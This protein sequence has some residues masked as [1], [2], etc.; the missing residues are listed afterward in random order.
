M[1]NLSSL[2]SSSHPLFRS[3][4]Q[5]HP[6]D[7]KHRCVCFFMLQ[8]EES[9]GSLDSFRTFV[10]LT[11]QKQREDGWSGGEGEMVWAWE[12]SM[13]R[14]KGRSFSAKKSSSNALI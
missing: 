13:Q 9:K 12:E 11:S 1:Q 10:F 3:S 4:S 5:S 8:L 6:L 14:S 7:I 2:G